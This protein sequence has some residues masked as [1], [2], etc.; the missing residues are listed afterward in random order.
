MPAQQPLASPLFLREAEVRRGLELL[1]FGYGG[2]F[3][4]IDAPLEAAGLGRAHHRALY[5]IARRPDITVGALIGLLGVTK[6]SLGRT[7]NELEARALVETRVGRD[8]RRQRLLRLTPAGKAIEA[9][10]FEALR[11]ALAAAYVE[12]GPGAVGGF[13]QVLEGLIPPETRERTA[14]LPKT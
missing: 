12:A 7:L 13:W 10:L 2:L 4:A 6:Q 11:A 8:D 1:F 3:R 5:F 9:E 14:A